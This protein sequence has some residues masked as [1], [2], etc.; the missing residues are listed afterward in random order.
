M[1]IGMTLPVMEPGLD[2]DLLKSWT[3]KIEAGPWSS[4]ALGERIV[5]DNP[6]FISTLSAIAAWTNNIEIISTVSV[7]TMHDPVLS[8]KQFAT[9]DV[10]SNGRL[11]LGVG[12]GGRKEDYD[13][14]GGLWKDHKW[15][16]LSEFVGIMKSVWNDSYELK[17]G[18]KP[19]QENGPEI[20]SGA[21]GPKSI[22][23]A[24]EFSSGLAGFTFNADLQEVKDMKVMADESFL[25][26]GN[27]EPR[28]IT[29]F[30][31]ALG[32][33]ARA[34][35]RT[36]LQRYLG[37]MGKDI[38]NE[39]SNTAGFCGSINELKDFI[40]EIN[41]AGIEEILLVPTSKDLDQLDALV[42]LFEK[43]K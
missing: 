38:A 34:Q 29:S 13:S 27:K 33:D 1:K 25:K 3:E 24:S 2:R 36:H 40:R 5:F 4:I 30:W 9:I 14:I 32:A 12:V 18:P 20:L 11:T 41:Q 26:S 43:E 23:K 37:W 7:L 19:V 31:F 35:M 8:A 28:L 22:K 39:L 16:R 15:Q 42:D 17:I 21:L 10:I 6:E